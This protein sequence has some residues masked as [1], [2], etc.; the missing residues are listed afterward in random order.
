[1]KTRVPLLLSLVFAAACSD[2]SVTGPAPLGRVVA[3]PTVAGAAAA[4]RITVMTR[5]LYIGADVDQVITALVSGGDVLAALE[6]AVETVLATSYPARAEAM[7]DEIAR[8]RPQFVGLQ[9]VTELHLDL[10]ALGIPVIDQPFLTILEG[11]LSARGL[12]YQLAGQNTNTA[13]TLV[14]GPISVSVVDHD[15]ILVDASRVETFHLIAAPHFTNNIGPLAGG[16]IDLERGFVLID[17]TISGVTVKVANTH[18]EAGV[19]GVDVSL[20]RA[21]QAGELVTAVGTGPAILL[22]DFNSTQT[23]LAYAVVTGAPPAGGGFTDAWAALRPGAPGLTC[24]ELPDLS[25]HVNVLSGRIDYVLARGL[26]GPQG[27]L[28]GQVT[29][30]GDQPGDRVPGLLYPVWPSDHAGVVASLL[31]PPAQG[32][33]AR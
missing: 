22:G 27:R 3:A 6:G 11:A 21:A 33:A 4:T 24:C 15:A 19:T 29:I 5:N 26:A 9:E 10:S 8:T 25:N 7:A 18:L 28:L 14:F 12:N 1:M 23:S 32:L 17:A 20:L 13:A 16:L 31:L 2:S 30:V